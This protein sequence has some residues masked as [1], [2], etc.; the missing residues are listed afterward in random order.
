MSRNRLI[1]L[2][3]IILGL[4]LILLADSISSALLSETNKI[5]QAE[6]FA[7]TLDEKTDKA[8][9]AIHELQ[10]DIEAYGP[11]RAQALRS[12]GFK[13]LF[14]EENIALFV[15][16]NDDLILWT[17]NTISP[18]SARRAATLGTEIY[19]FEN[20]WYRL[21]YFTNGIDEYVSAILISRTFPYH[22]EYLLSGFTDDFKQDNV[23]AI[24]LTGAEGRVKLKADHQNFYLSFSD[25]ESRSKKKAFFFAL[26]ALLGG[27]LVLF[28]ILSVYL[29]EST[30][31]KKYVLFPSLVITLVGL[32]YFTLKADWP[33]VTAN[34]AAFDPVLYASSVISPTFAD[35]LINVL[36]IFVLSFLARQGMAQ[37]KKGNGEPKFLVAF[38]LGGALL[39][40]QGAWINQ[41]AKELVLNSSVPFEINNL[42]QLTLSS[43]F[44]VL[45][46]GVLYFSALM[47]AD[48]LSLFAKIKGLIFKSALLSGLI[49]TLI[50]VVGTHTVGIKDLAFVLWPPFVLIAL[51]YSRLL[52]QSTVFRFPEGALILI[53]FSSLGAYNFK[54]YMQHREQSEVEIIAE[55]LAINDDPIAE[56]LFDGQ[57]EELVRDPN[58]R[59]L[60]EQEEL[61]SRETLED[62]IVSRYFTGY[63][64]KYD[65][66]LHAFTTDKSVWGKL[67]ATRPSGFDDLEKDLVTYSDLDSLEEGFHFLYNAP[68]RIAYIGVLPL[69]YNLRETPD[70]FLIFEFAS[71]LF[72]QQVGFPNLLIDRELGSKKENEQYSTARYSDGRLTNSR[73]E[74]PYPSKPEVFRRQ[75]TDGIK[76]F[77]LRGYEHYISAFNDDDVVVVSKELYGPL[78]K[79]TM[80][81]YLSVIYGILFSLMIALF[82][83][84]QNREFLR[85]NLNRKVQALLVILTVT[86]MVLF[87]LATKY[88]IEE[89][90]SEKNERLI[91]EKMHS[92][93]L[94]L[95]NKLEDEEGLNYEMS[96]YLNRILS[97]FSVIFFTDINLFNPQGD[98]IASSQMRMFNEGLISRKIDPTA[99]AYMHYLDQIEYI[100][101]E[102]VG[103]LS[104]LSAYS[105][106]LNKRGE[107]IGYANLP[108]FARQTELTNEIS[109]FLVS[110]INLFVLVFVLSL[111]IALFISQWIT[112]PLRSIRESLSAIELGKANRL[113]GYK[114]QDE[115]GL[116]VDEYN[117][118]VSELEMNAAKLSQSERESAW[119]EMAKQVAHEIK[120]PLTPMKL[121]VQH[122]ER[123]LLAD[124]SVDEEKVTRVMKN[125][126]EQIDTLTTIANAFSGFAKMPKAKVE[127]I[128][129]KDTVES[130]VELFSGF[131]RIDFET[132]YP[133]KDSCFVKADKDQSI[134]LFN[135]LLKN[136]VQS[137][138]EERRGHISI[139][140]REETDGYA[141]LISDNGSGIEKNQM[142]KLFIPN[143]TTKTRGMGLGLAMSKNI[144]E[145]FGGEISFTSE[146]GKGSQF[147]VW[148][149]KA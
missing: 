83:F 146:L 52:T 103:E 145:N 136:A 26:T 68:D 106:L 57:M 69:N 123:T 6:D 9:R 56:V 118:K 142:P 7:Q 43:L 124:G 93:L 4:A 99:Y 18:E 119:R 133:A 77:P 23:E 140:I 71:T 137:M 75:I 87:S 54:K 120:N 8:V 111:I 130:A 1:N 36:L 121:S 110:V 107:I 144:V 40:L 53:V 102:A 45:S 73:G 70:G 134:R 132:I 17:D 91:S 42:N 131:D 39:F 81:T 89:K 86:T 79:I 55:K 139:E 101:E 48:G 85:L 16:R 94:E 27:G 62:Y 24:H 141:T 10:S 92:I 112:L 33:S 64:S 5:D 3:L 72:P 104:Y 61:H 67:P 113:V 125:L 108:Y 34:L 82:R 98:L 30:G 65:I 21:V 88:Y 32:R 58:V 31:R 50:W 96:D 100:Q 41:V 126:I 37:A 122:L 47:I 19:H 13:A 11:K 90:Y 22:N 135:N 143:F 97:Q 117:A 129:L 14:Q 63:W 76:F 147:K 66:T 109:S 116:L 49:L 59:T 2:L 78:D 46:V 115:I 105:P 25:E 74:Y 127:T 95:E 35:F 20:G 15:F 138:T 29:A 149:P 60:F 114:G 84:R 128:N 51:L 80:V 44:G 12:E 28:A 38:F 148:L